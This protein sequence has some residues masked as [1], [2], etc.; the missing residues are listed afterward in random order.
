M[1]AL[2]AEALLSAAAGCGGG[3]DS[4]GTDGGT[5]GTAGKAKIRELTFPSGVRGT[6]PRFSPDGA[7]VAYNRDEGSS[8]AVAVMS[9]AGTDSRNLATDG[10][11]L[12]AMVWSKDGAEII[13][14]GDRDIRALP[15]AGGPS[16]QVVNA[17]AAVGPDLSPDGKSLV[18]GINGSNLQLADLTR[19]PPVVTDLGTPGSAP[20][21]SPDGSAIAYWSGDTLRVM[22]LATQATTDVLTGD[23]NL[24]FG[25]VDW[26][27]D[28]R[29]LAGTAR[30]VEIVTPGPP[31]TRRLVSDVFALLDVDLS[32]DEAQVAYAINGQQ[33][34]FFLSGF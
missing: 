32:P 29:L 3:G 23:A 10:S 1:L 30:G 2:S 14:A 31:V 16:R 18:Y 22:Q 5:G 11:Y 26:F 15:A 25:G 28:G 6:S 7:Q 19:S 33:S 13:Y 12:T 20:R 21:F 27:G 17:F 24:G 8:N 34:L 4:A 9:L